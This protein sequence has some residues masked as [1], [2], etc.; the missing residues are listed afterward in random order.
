MLNS[1]T[2]QIAAA[3]FHLVVAMSDL[4]D[5]P[6]D[7][8]E[9][10][11]NHARLQAVLDALGAPISVA[12]LVAAYFKDAARVGRGDVHVFEFDPDGIDIL[13]IDTFNE[14]TD[15]LDLIELFVRCAGHKTA[16]VSECVWKYFNGCEV[17]VFAS[18]QAVC[19][20]LREALDSNRFPRAIGGG[21][22]LQRQ[23]RHAA[24]QPSAPT[25]GFAARCA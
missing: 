20:R 11:S 2:P 3:E 17:Q 14:P 16:Q 1:M 21:G 22:S 19:S 23:I 6:A 7:D 24:V 18:Q 15:Q 9:P 5:W 25:V 13:A 4:V 8:G 10:K 12:P